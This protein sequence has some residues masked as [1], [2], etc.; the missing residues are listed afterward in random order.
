MK[1]YFE[2][3][4]NKS[5]KFWEVSAENNTLT[6]RYGKIGSKGISKNKEFGDNPAVVKEAEK[7]IKEKLRKGYEEVGAQEVVEEESEMEENYFEPIF[8]DLEGLLESISWSLEVSETKKET[9]DLAKHTNLIEVEELTSKQGILDALD[10]VGTLCRQLNDEEEDGNVIF[11]FKDSQQRYLNEK[12]FFQWAAQIAPKKVAAVLD[13]FVKMDGSEFL[14]YDAETTALVYAAEALGLYSKAHMESVLAYLYNVDWEHDVYNHESLIPNVS[15]KWGHSST[16]LHFRIAVLPL[17]IW[18]DLGENFFD[19]IGKDGNFYN[20]WMENSKE[21]PFILKEIQELLKGRYSSEIKGS[22]FAV[23]FFEALEKVLI[24]GSSHLKKFSLQVAKFLD[25]KYPGNSFVERVHNVFTNKE[26]ELLKL[27]ETAFASNDREDYLLYAKELNR[28]IERLLNIQGSPFQEKVRAYLQEFDDCIKAKPDE[29]IALLYT[30]SIFQS[31]KP[32]YNIIK[33][34]DFLPKLY[35][36][37]KDYYT[38]QELTQIYLKA[39]L[40]NIASRNSD[41]DNPGS[42]LV[43]KEFEEINL[44]KKKDPDFPIFQ[45]VSE[46]DFT[47]H[48]LFRLCYHPFHFRNGIEDIKISPNGQ[49]IGVVGDERDISSALLYQIDGRPL[50]PLET[51]MGDRRAHRL[52]FSSTSRYVVVDYHD[53]LTVLETSTGKLLHQLKDHS[54][55]G[56]DFSLED[57]GMQFS[58]DDRYLAAGFNEGTVW[59]WDIHSGVLQFAQGA[60]LVGKDTP[61]QWRAFNASNISEEPNEKPWETEQG[62]KFYDDELIKIDVF[63]WLNH[64]SLLIGNSTGLYHWDLEQNQINFLFPGEILGIAIWIN[65]EDNSKYFLAVWD[66]SSKSRENNGY[67]K[68]FDEKW[69]EV[70]SIKLDYYGHSG[71][72]SFSPDGKM[73]QTLY[74]RHEWKKKRTMKESEYIGVISDMWWDGVSNSTLSV[75]KFKY[76]RVSEDEDSPLQEIMKVVKESDEKWSKDSIFVVWRKE[77]R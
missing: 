71:W 33:N 50:R 74:A 29:S 24:E 30:R 26:G 60:S 15:A 19:Q 57:L 52:A 53:V 66:V 61:L 32:S 63:C 59:I 58:P 6:V 35:A 27:K 56:D 16:G 77:Y 10:Q 31:F 64:T 45:N 41:A 18:F 68:I 4:D 3:K 9:I 67:I 5:S 48:D 75:G 17:Y 8:M 11:T 69:K 13:K 51:N 36:L 22:D 70:R 42:E 34:I 21:H 49:M 37:W 28:E 47:S 76:C 54:V 46:Q 12:D 65:P 73:L 14:Y 72:L 39:L 55:F 23:W 40:L 20:W 62:R 44:L 7:L 43:A 25:R 2:Y 1:R 38:N